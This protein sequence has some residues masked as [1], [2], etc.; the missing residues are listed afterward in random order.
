M[1]KAFNAVNTYGSWAAA[2]TAHEDD[3]L[4]P[5]GFVT[6]M[7]FDKDYKFLDV[8]YDQLD[9]AYEQVGVTP[10]APHGFVIAEYTARE[11]GY[12]YAFISNESPTLV[13]IY[14]D[15]VT[16][17]IT[18]SNVIQ[19]NEYY[20]FGLQTSRSWTRTDSKNDYLYNGGAEF[21]NA[22]GMYDLFYG[23]TIQQREGLDRLIRRLCSIL[24]DQLM[25]TPE[26]T[27]FIIMTPWE[28]NSA[29][30]E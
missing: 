17:G 13:D 3:E 23:T 16:I 12:A 20:P 2:G 15:D 22:T 11:E 24:P 6:I 25:P 9:E 10:K 27:P 29:T 7:L 14:F 1:L 4:S 19:Y 26:I 18:K 5:K 30:I 21:N 28:T 8:A